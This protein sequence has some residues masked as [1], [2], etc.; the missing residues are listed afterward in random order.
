MLQPL[1]DNGVAYVEDKVGQKLLEVGRV[2]QRGQ[3][4]VEMADAGQGR[5]CLVEY[6]D[7]AEQ[8]VDA[9]VVEAA[10]AELAKDDERALSLQQVVDEFLR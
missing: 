9:L 10:G 6:D 8:V 1:A 5:Q 2:V 3:H 4:F 7:V